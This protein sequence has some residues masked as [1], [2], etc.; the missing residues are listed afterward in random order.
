M[1]PNWTT[2]ITDHQVPLINYNFSIARPGIYF[3]SFLYLGLGLGAY[4]IGKNI[5]YKG[6]KGFIKYIKTWGNSAKYL[7]SDSPKD[8]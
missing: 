6:Y 4:W 5:L 3:T 2:T 8:E 7:S 1:T